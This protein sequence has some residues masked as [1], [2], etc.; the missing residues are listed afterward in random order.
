[1]QSVSNNIRRGQFRHNHPLAGANVI[2]F[3]T[4][5]SAN[6][7]YKLMHRLDGARI[8]GPILLGLGG[9][10]LKAGDAVEDIV[11]M[12]TVAVME[13]QGRWRSLYS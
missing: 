12:A 9:P 7:A 10:V 6:I 3:P 2:V 5:A 11:N 4:L 1:M 8:I 13:A